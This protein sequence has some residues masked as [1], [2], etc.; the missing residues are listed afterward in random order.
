MADGYRLTGGS[1]CGHRG[2]SFRITSSDPTSE[3]TT[4]ALSGA[5]LSP[6]EQAGPDDG[7]ARTVITWRFGLKQRQ[8]ALCAVGGPCGDKTPVGFAQ[9]LR[10]FHHPTLRNRS[11]ST[12]PCRIG[13]VARNGCLAEAWREIEYSASPDQAGPVNLGW[14]WTSNLRP[15]MTELG[16]VGGY[17]FDDADWA[18]VE[19]GVG[20]TDPSAGA[21]FEYPVGRFTVRVAVENG[22]VLVEVDGENDDDRNRLTWM[23]HLMQ[24]WHLGHREGD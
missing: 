5:Q 10:R 9:R 4:D 14:I 17:T 1:G 21:W 20:G 7:S 24:N 2:G 22:H 12:A 3:S 19:Y 8:N 15:F 16:L 23:T 11:G 13:R 6:G 18:A